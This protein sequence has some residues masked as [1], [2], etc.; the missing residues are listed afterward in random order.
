M[1]QKRSKITKKTIFVFKSLSRSIERIE[2]DP[3]VSTAT[4][5]TIKTFF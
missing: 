2:T 1:T 3:T 5:T 4:I